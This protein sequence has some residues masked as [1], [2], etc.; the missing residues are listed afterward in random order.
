[1]IQTINE[2]VAFFLTVMAVILITPMLSEWAHLPGIVGIILGGML[3]GPHGFHLLDIGSPIEFLAV[4]GLVYLMFSAGLEVDIQQFNRVRGRSFVF[5][6]FTFLLPAGFGILLGRLLGL[7]W[8]G[9]VLLGSAFSSHTLIAF[10]ILARL[11]VI[12]NEAVAVTVGATVMTDIG[13]FI[14]LAFVLGMQ[15]GNLNPAHFLVLLSLLALLAF[16]ILYGLPRLGKVF[17]RRFHGRAA[18]FQFVLLVVLVAALL[19][20]KIGVH[21]VVG[22]FLAGLAINTTLPPRSPVT[23]HI[24]FMG[25]SFFIP[26]FL[27]YS[28]MMTDPSAFIGSAETILVALG[29][30]LV[31]YLSKF[32]AALV[33]ARIF[34][35]SRDEFFTAFGLSHAQ[36]A[37][38]IPT[39]V[40]GLEVGLFSSTLFNAAILMILLTSITSPLIVQHFAGRLSRSQPPEHLSPL[41][42]RV[43]VPLVNPQTQV[44]LLTLA[45]ILTRAQEGT[46][47]ALNVAR[48]VN[49]KV[50]GLVQQQELLGMMGEILNDPEANVQLLPRVDR[51]ITRGIL[52]AA[53]ENNATLILM[54]WRGKPTVRESALGTVLDDVLRHSTI[55][56]LAGRLSIP[57]NGVSRVLL[58]APANSLT[59]SGIQRALDI[60][61]TLTKAM[62][63][64]LQILADKF[65][66]NRFVELAPPENEGPGIDILPLKGMSPRAILPYVDLSTLTIVANTIPGKRFLAGLGNL[67]EHLAA[68]TPA[69]IMVL[70]IN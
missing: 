10:P 35:Y 4:I 61:L 9:S 65:Y 70:H 8:L 29:V 68:A 5:G 48:D 20:E 54:G 43:L 24:L 6:L 12:R 16:V 39:L 66:R 46:L 51:S 2:P 17:F 11:G 50:V 64:P 62:N 28:G 58:V 47:L 13:A 1:M 21:E 22:A 23:G 42:K 38:T 63:V 32:L 3:V 7:G 52:H 60:V 26:V 30:T 37:V 36:A 33:T 56:V 53:M 34:H 41:F 69:D 19:A 25:E 15:Q 49:G 45:S 40:I 55:P 14:V 67:P 57:V 59:P 27:M 31:A 44:H 18:E